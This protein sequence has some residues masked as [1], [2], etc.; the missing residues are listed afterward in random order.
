[1]DIFASLGLATDYPS[2]D[3]L[4]RKPEP[5]TA[6]IVSVT[7]WKMVLLVAIYQ[8]A[9]VFTFHY[10]GESLFQPQN[11]F[12]RKQLQTMVFNIY[13]WMQFFNQ[14]NCRRVDNKINIWYQGVLRNPWFIGVQCLTLAGQMIIIWFAGPAFDTERLTAAQWGW[15]MLFGALVIPIGA[16]IRQI[17]DRF[18]L[19]FFHAVARAFRP[20]KRGLLAILRLL[21]KPLPEKWRP[22]KRKQGGDELGATEAWVLQTGAAL[23][24]PV[25][26]QWGH[27]GPPQSNEQVGRTQSITPAQRE[28]LAKAIQSGAKKQAELDIVALI[29]QARNSPGSVDVNIEVHPETL[30]EDPLLRTPGPKDKPPSQDSHVLDWVKVGSRASGKGDTD[31]S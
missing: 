25:N 14:H 23:L 21:T 2:R 7:M 11:D 27:S 6:P 29:N 4:K 1:M 12:E 26:Y 19:M 5:R 22:K 24:R 10:A 18:V 17:P 30:K 13:V 16:L 9:V 31:A 20:V 15:S 3:F 28:A 8:L